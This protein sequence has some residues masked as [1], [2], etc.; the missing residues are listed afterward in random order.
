MP[1]FI[2]AAAIALEPGRFGFNDIEY[3]EPLRYD[4]VDIDTPMDLAVAAKLTGVKT[5]VI[6]ELNPELR[7]WC[8]PPNVSNYTLKIPAGTRNMFLAGLSNTNEKELFYSNKF[9]NYCNTCMQ[10][11]EK[12]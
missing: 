4:T 6:K 8:T 7:R 1:S 9:I 3:Q 12:R 5:F 10:Q 11:R 2:A